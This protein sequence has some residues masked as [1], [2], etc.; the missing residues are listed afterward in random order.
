M[1]SN[2]LTSQ[3]ISFNDIKYI[4]LRDYQESNHWAILQTVLIMKI[5]SQN[6]CGNYWCIYFFT[7]R[8][9]PLSCLNKQNCPPKRPIIADVWNCHLRK[10]LIWHAIEWYVDFD[11]VFIYE[12]LNV[13]K[14]RFF[15]KWDTSYFFIVMSFLLLSSIFYVLDS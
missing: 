1:Y 13:E 8:Q 11:L 15:F 5:I 12:M 10:H 14:Y 9:L 7:A 4:H 2:F 6:L 3:N